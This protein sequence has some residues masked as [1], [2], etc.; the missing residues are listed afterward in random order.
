MRQI[1]FNRSIRAVIFVAI[2]LLLVAC[3]G[4]GSTGGTQPASNAK[5]QPVNGFGIAANHVHS[6]IALPSHVLVL[7]THYG[8]FRSQDNGASWQQVAAGPAQLM[9]GL[10]TYALTYSPLAPQRLYVLSQIATT[11]H[12]APFALYPSAPA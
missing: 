2:A 4:G 9:G 11:P 12:P 8:I 7:A 3:N 10:M 6:L 1:Q 5:P